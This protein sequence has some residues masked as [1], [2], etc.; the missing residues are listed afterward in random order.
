MSLVFAGIVPHPPLIIPA[1]C[2]DETKKVAKTGEALSKLEEDLYLAKPE[3][4]IIVSPH[5]QLFADAFSLN[6]CPE[7]ETDLREFGDLVTKNKYKGE[8]NL[9]SDIREMGKDEG[10][11]ISMNCDGKLDHGAAV[12]LFFLLPHLPNVK[13][14]PIGYSGLDAKTHVKFGQLIKEAIMKTNKRVAVIASGD[15][16]HALTSEAPAGFSPSGKEFDAKIQEL[17]STRNTAGM[18]K[19]EPKFL[20]EAAECG[21][22][23]FLILMGIL[24][25]VS[26]NYQS[27]SYE[28]P[29]GVGYLVA[30]LAV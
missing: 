16:S 8:I 5:G 19:L 23:S 29:F 3:I 18:L 2:K 13:I 21:F 10:I 28:A 17:L 26:Y 7:F 11:P 6:I 22:R 25:D 4:V 27:Y 9:A 30:N 24:R 20:E 15:L 14:L 1:I 12:P